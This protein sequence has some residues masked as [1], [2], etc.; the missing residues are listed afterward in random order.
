MFP[1]KRQYLPGKR[2]YVRGRRAGLLYG[3]RICGRFRGRMGVALAVSVC[4]VIN[5]VGGQEVCDKIN[6][7]LHV[8]V[9]AGVICI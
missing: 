3:W 5:P 9:R 7:M 6:H 4:G 8:V 1:G 2:I